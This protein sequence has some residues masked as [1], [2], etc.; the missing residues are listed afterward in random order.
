MSTSQVAGAT[1]GRPPANL[2]RQIVTWVGLGL[3]SLTFVIAL[4]RLFR[5]GGGANVLVSAF[6]FT[7]T[8]ALLLGCF[9]LTR[10]VGARVLVGTF[11]GG[12]FGT[13]SLALL[14][15]HPVINHFGPDS[16]FAV[17]LWGPLTEEALK[18][19]PV[20]IF[21]LMSLLNTRVRPSIG[22]AVLL[23]VVAAV[24]FSVHENALYGRGTNGGWFAHLPFSLF[25]PSITTMPGGQDTMLVGGHVVYTA[26]TSLGLAI[27]VA[28]WRRSK[29]ARLAAPM[30]FAVAVLEHMTVNRFS[31][32]YLAEP[33]LWARVAHIA[34]LGGY[35]SSILLV[36]GLAAIT[37]IEWRL[38]RASGSWRPPI[39][40]TDLI[41]LRKAEAARR[42]A[43]FAKARTGAATTM[44]ATHHLIEPGHQ[45]PAAV[46]SNPQGNRK[47]WS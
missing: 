45:A 22:D 11:F 36:G 16:P 40:S 43:A 29:L 12:F 6:Q 1:T 3:S 30:T 24:G 19:L 41:L 7:W 38:V 21:L 4:P 31:M 28:Y 23:G 2:V 15:G 42:G 8:I 26:L 17:A 25:A 37:F 34:T 35:L 44:S 27:T 46:T 9:A 32:S 47:A 5:S 33:P 13:V 39:R 18:L 14:V 10:T 20:A